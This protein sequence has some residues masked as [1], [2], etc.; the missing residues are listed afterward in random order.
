MQYNGNRKKRKCGDLGEKEKLSRQSNEK[1]ITINDLHEIVLEIKNSI[2]PSI[3]KE[4]A[5][6]LNSEIDLI[7]EKIEEIEMT[8]KLQNLKINTLISAHPM[9]LFNHENLAE[10]GEY[11]RTG[12]GFNSR[13]VKWKNN[14][15]L[16]RR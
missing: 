1:Q 12:S 4:I 9:M 13:E 5:S 14:P 11:V 6:K 16:D 8:I 15:F 10:Y 3:E 7:R 2:L